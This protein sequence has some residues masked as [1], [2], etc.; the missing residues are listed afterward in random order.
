MT[1]GRFDRHLLHGA[2]LVSVV[3]LMLADREFLGWPLVFGVIGIMVAAIAYEE[4]LI[5]KK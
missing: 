3:F 5:W 2:L 1:R 4:C